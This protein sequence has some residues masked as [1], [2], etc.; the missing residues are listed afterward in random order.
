VARALYPR[1]RWQRAVKDASEH[2]AAK[3]AERG[4][5]HFE[6]SPEFRERLRQEYESMVPYEDVVAYQAGILE[7]TYSRSEL[8]SLLSFFES[9]TGQKSLR[10]L[11]ELVHDAD[12][13]LQL[14]LLQKLPGAL[15]RLRPLVRQLPDEATGSSAAPPQ[16]GWD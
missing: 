11:N 6:L 3:I 15:Q 8:T 16:G 1:E 10:F 14:G 12:N 7:S 5:G 13:Q 2:M 9:P 4:T